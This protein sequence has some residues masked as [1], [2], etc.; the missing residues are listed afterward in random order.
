MAH[1]AAQ[2]VDATI[3][4]SGDIEA[5]LAQVGKIDAGV[6]GSGEIS[7]K[8]HNCGAVNATITGSGDIELS[9]TAQTLKQTTQGSGDISTNELKLTK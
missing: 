2:S 5:T 9:G 4:G 8:L 6:T 3:T 7:M 1:I